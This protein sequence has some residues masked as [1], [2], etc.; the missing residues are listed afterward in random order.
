[1]ISAAVAKMLVDYGGS[2]GL[3]DIESVAHTLYEYGSDQDAAGDAARMSLR[4]FI[5]DIHTTLSEISA[6]DELDGFEHELNRLMREYG[7]IDGRADR[8]IG[9]RRESLLE[10]EEHNDEEGYGR[11]SSQSQ[12]EFSDDQ[13]RSMFQGLRGD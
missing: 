10:G 6:L 12:P 1:M 5:S 8:E 13:I 11:S 7:L 2:L 9:S 3:D 4:A